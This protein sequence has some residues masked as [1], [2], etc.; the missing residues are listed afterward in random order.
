MTDIRPDVVAL[1]VDVKDLTEFAKGRLTHEDGRPFTP[2]EFQ[3]AS[4]ATAAEL[5]ACMEYTRRIADMYTER[6][7]DIDR[8]MEIMRPHFERLGPNATVGDVRQH[9][10]PEEGEELDGIFERTAPDGTIVI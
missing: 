10:T 8:G 5:R 4:S 7:R 3:L 1:L 6:Q 9:V 2:D